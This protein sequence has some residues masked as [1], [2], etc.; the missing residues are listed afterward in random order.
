[1]DKLLNWTSPPF[2]LHSSAFYDLR[3]LKQHVIGLSSHCNTQNKIT[4]K[5]IITGKDIFL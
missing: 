1:M 2:I 4:V 3:N 5:Q